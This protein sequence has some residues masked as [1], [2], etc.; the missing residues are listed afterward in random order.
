M[1]ILC[2]GTEDEKSQFSFALMDING[3]GLISFEEFY[4]YFNQ[5]I[6]HWSSLINSHVRV[7]RSEMHDIFR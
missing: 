3:N 1:D 7:N 2:N 4:Q 5:V 6:G